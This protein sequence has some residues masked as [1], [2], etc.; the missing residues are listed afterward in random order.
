[1]KTGIFNPQ[2]EMWDQKSYLTLCNITELQRIKKIIYLKMKVYK[3]A[4]FDAVAC[5]K[6]SELCSDK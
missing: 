2:V 1:M 5:I 6:C 4:I 3:C